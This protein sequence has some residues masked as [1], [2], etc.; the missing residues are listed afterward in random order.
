MQVLQ[1]EAELCQGRFSPAESVQPLFADGQSVQTATPLLLEAPVSE[2]KGG[3]L[4]ETIHSLCYIELPRTMCQISHTLP[5]TMIKHRQ[6]GTMRELRI[7]A[8]AET[9]SEAEAGAEGVIW[10]SCHDVCAQLEG[11]GARA[12]PHCAAS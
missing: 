1:L 5:S 10:L 12:S 7:H 2:Q 8:K 4:A 3:M 6:S 11:Q 9:G